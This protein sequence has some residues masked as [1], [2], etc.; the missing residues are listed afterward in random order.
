MKPFV[1]FYFTP[2]PFEFSLYQRIGVPFLGRYCPNGGSRFSVTKSLVKRR[3][4]RLEVLRAFVKTTIVGETL[5][6]LTAVVM[7]WQMIDAC[8]GARYEGAAANFGVNVTINAYPIMLQ[9]YNRARALLAISRNSG[10]FCIKVRK[11]S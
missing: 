4:S 2:R 11:L 6:V 7:V 1:Q 5:H 8:R 3:G 10:C 9:R